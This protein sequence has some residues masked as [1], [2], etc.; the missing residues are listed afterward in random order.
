MVG[1]LGKYY[2][3]KELEAIKLSLAL[4]AKLDGQAVSPAVLLPG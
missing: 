2:G 3:R 4:Q 1:K